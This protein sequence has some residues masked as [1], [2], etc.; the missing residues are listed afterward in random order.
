MVTR[1]L[2]NLSQ[3]IELSM[4]TTYIL[5]AGA[6]RHAG[7][8]F[9]K[10]MGR[11]LFDWM[12]S[13]Q[14]C[15]FDFAESARILEAQYGID[16][17][18]V[19]NGMQRAIRRRASG[20]SLI[21]NCHKPAFVE[22]LRQWFCEIHQ[23]DQSDA[24]EQFANEVV[25]P[26]DC[27]VSFNYDISL[28]SKL[29][30]AGKW[31]VGDGYGFSVD[32]LAQGS[33]VKLLKLHGSINWFAILFGGVTNGPFTIG[34]DGAF[35]RRPALSDADLAALGYTDVVDPRFPRGG[36]A[37]VL[38]LILPTNRKQFFYQTNLG[39]EW[40]SFWNNLWR[41]ARKAVSEA[42]LIVVCGY[43]LYPID[44]RGCNLLLKGKCSGEI[45]ICCGGDS[46]R[47][48]AELVSHGRR[49]RI[50]HETRFENWVASRSP[51]HAADASSAT[52]AR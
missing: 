9:A 51:S 24:Y 20:Y 50:A 42:K 5:G 34:S 36:A 23:R 12:K 17:E 33:L 39:K 29:H 11:E 21:A 26:G 22:A 13:A 25:R 45:E 8:P 52:R 30:H 19:M 38:P 27:I 43:G 48:L 4:S 46:D 1:L 15:H 41:Q 31:E 7:Y 3:H 47:I 37:A 35:G 6:S 14:S 10:S 32:G 16:I 40:A 28:D 44:R 2:S 49:A 18:T